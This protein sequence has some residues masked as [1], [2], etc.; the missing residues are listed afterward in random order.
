[1]DT[2]YK[3]DMLKQILREKKELLNENSDLMERKKIMELEK[4]FNNDRCFFH[5][6]FDTAI[7]ILRFLDI[8]EESILETYKELTAPEL[9]KGSFQFK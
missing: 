4:L 6:S 8:P 5:I 3:I 9:I 2:I 7:N 1:M